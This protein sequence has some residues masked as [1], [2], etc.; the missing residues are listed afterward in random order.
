VLAAPA[1]DAS[2]L[3]QQH[4]GRALALSLDVTDAEQRKATIAQAERQFGSIDI[5][6]NNA[7]IDFLGAIE[8]QDEQDYRRTFDVNFFGA[9]EMI[10]AVL[11]QTRANGSGM[12]VNVSSMDGFASLP[13]NG[14]YS[15]SKFAL[16]G[17]TEAL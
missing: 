8:E 16:E 7:G 3:V 13:A 4:P 6:V 2:E 17:M 10:R 11:P 9:V 12:I 15:A 14:F 5:L 1:I